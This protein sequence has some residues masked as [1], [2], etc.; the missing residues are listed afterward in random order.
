MDDRKLSHFRRVG[1]FRSRIGHVF[2]GSVGDGTHRDHR[3]GRMLRLLSMFEYGRHHFRYGRFAQL[4]LRFFVLVER[5]HRSD[6]KRVSLHMRFFIRRG[7]MVDVFGTFD[8]GV[9][10]HFF[11]RFGM[12]DERLA[13][14]PL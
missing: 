12:F 10:F 5:Y 6:E 8:V 3:M 14:A 11:R 2:F 7:T 9:L 13:V 1:Y 4:R